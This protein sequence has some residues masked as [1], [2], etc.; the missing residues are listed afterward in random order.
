MRMQLFLLLCLLLLILM[1]L[2]FWHM[3]KKLYKKKQIRYALLIL[4]L[5]GSVFLIYRFTPFFAMYKD[6]MPMRGALV[7]VLN[8]VY[9]AQM[10]G[11]CLLALLH[12]LYCRRYSKEFHSRL[13]V[14]ASVV[15]LL[16][17]VY[18]IGCAAR[19]KVRQEIVEL[20]GMNFC[21][22]LTCMQVQRFLHLIIL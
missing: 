2:F 4:S 19:V 20:K 10:T 9:V 17:S 6:A 8:S 11:F 12:K 16:F 14:L 3:I 7:L 22:S 1:Q 18:G 13:Y 5:L 15:M 21:I